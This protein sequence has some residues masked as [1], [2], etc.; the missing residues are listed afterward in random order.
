M[1]DDTWGK[2]YNLDMQNSKDKKLNQPSLNHLAIIMDGNGRWAKAKGLTRLKGHQ[3]GAK[4]VL[5]IAK[6]AKVMNIPYLSLF[7]FSTE[8]WSRPKL[9]VNGLFQL[10]NEFVNKYLKTLHEDQ[11]RLVI[12]GLI[13]G[14]PLKTQTLLKRA[15]QETKDYQRY[16]LNIC[17][18]Y[19]GQ[20]EIVRATQKAINA[21]QNGLMKIEDI[22]PINFYQFLDTA[23]LPPVDCL[24]R[25]SGEQRISNFL[26]YQIAYAEF[27]FVAK[28]WPDFKAADL[29][30]VIKSYQERKRRFGKL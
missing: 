14:L 9:E 10:L 13:E 26:L 12:S 23:N 30:L 19:G 27:V 21:V 17:V 28:S 8:N 11:V 4:R 20:D 7:A 22:T 29:Q 24:V 3:E 5:E 1:G 15:I 18:N 6:E 16:T 2:L 25:T